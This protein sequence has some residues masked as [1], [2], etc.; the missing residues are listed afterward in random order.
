MRKGKWIQGTAPGD[1]VS[2]AAREALRARLRTVAYY[3]PLASFKSDRDIEY[4][5]QVR[6]STRRAVALLRIFRSLMAEKDA[7][8]LDRKLKRIRRAASEAR[9]LDVLG[10]RI[11]EW[12][13]ANPSSGR[14]ALLYRVERAR[15]GAQAPVRKVRKKLADKR[16]GGRI[17]K[18]VKRVRWREDGPEPSFAAA[19]AGC[20]RTVA[21]PFFEAGAGDTAD[22]DALH[23]FR[24]TAK[25]L[26]YSMEVF[27]AAFGPD[28][29]TDLYPCFE[30]VQARL[31]DIHDHAA[32][33]AR[34][35]TWLAEWDDGPETEALR[36]LAEVEKGNL[37]RTRQN[38]IRWW[39]PERAA[40]LRT[41]F[42]QAMLTQATV[43]HATAP[44]EKSA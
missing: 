27:A 23:R 44:G 41:R 6:V 9:D 28:F 39:T 14:A 33:L 32:A 19:A 35:Q 42:D 7:D 12:V 25:H 5:H 10:R 26:R 2:D 1:P 36:E 37:A 16:F 31:G 29:R 17:D 30:E 20:L 11:A 38:F 21:E 34:F 18:I 22:L 3:L 13:E 8:W 24:I 43:H 40:E 4:V 15:D